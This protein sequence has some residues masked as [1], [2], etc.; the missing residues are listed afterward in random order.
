MIAEVNENKCRFQLD[1]SKVYWNSRLSTEHERIIG[2]LNIDKDI[3]FDLFAGVGPFSVPA[4]KRRCRTYANDLNPESVK[5]LATNMK[6]N[7]VQEHMY[8]IHNMDAKQ[9]TQDIIKNKLVDEYKRILEEDSHTKPK[10]HFIMNLP[11]LAPT[12]LPLFAGLMRSEQM[13]R[14]AD[15][16]NLIDW[17]R[18][19]SI[20]HIVYC[21]C[22]LKG[23]YED[24]KKEVRAII[25]QN[26]GRKLTPE[27]FGGVFRVRNVAPY[28]EMYRIEIKLDENILFETKVVSIMKNVDG[29]LI[30]NGISKRVTIQAPNNKRD[31][32][33]T[34]S[35]E[36]LSPTKKSRYT[37]YCSLM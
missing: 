36:D 4:A 32:D 11:G 12:F 18:E 23:F 27:Q 33:D 30:P 8:E 29:G 19:Q 34:G 16:L 9:F 31:H 15:N 35:S 3:V 37:D 14:L 2:K 28:K 1:F 10:I 22:F 24:P 5:W 20:E 6:R 7:K 21:Y 13:T 17:F 25:E 26:F